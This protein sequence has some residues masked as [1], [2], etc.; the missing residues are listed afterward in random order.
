MGRLCEEAWREGLV[1]GAGEGARYLVGDP[2]VLARPVRRLRHR[3]V[4]RLVAAVLVAGLGAWAPAPASATAGQIDAEAMRLAL[5]AAEGAVTLAG[6]AEAFTAAYV[7]HGGSEAD[8]ARALQS[9]AADGFGAPDPLVAHMVP[10]RLA[11][12]TSPA[13]AL[14]ALPRASRAPLA[15]PT[16]RAVQRSAAAWR[17]EPRRAPA[18]PRA[19]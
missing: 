5:D 8:A 9:L 10:E 15:L 3:L 1:S 2:P 4:Q 6:A 19:P 16:A 11:P 14:A 7:A 12:P 17:A 13:R 18:Q